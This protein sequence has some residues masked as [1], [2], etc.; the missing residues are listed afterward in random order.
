MQDREILLGHILSTSMGGCDDVYNSAVFYRRRR[1][2]REKEPLIDGGN[3]LT[4]DETR[5]HH[6]AAIAEK[7]RSFERRKDLAA[8]VPAVLV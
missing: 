2:A 4:K 8:G 6:I 1:F 7:M 5:E 3:N